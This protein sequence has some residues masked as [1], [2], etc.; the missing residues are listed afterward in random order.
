MQISLQK[1]LNI[2]VPLQ[3]SNLMYPNYYL[4]IHL[5]KTKC[6][7]NLQIL[8]KMIAILKA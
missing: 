8:T 1:L 5:E 2:F 4:F 7:T 3:F 6:I